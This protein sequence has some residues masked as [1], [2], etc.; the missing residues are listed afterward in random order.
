MESRDD[1]RRGGGNPA[2]ATTCIILSRS[3][4]GYLGSYHRSMF[5]AGPGPTIVAYR[6]PARGRSVLIPDRT[7]GRGYDNSISDDCAHRDSGGA[8]RGRHVC[9]HGG[10]G[11]RG[12]RLAD[13]G[14]RHRHRADRRQQRHRAGPVDLKPRAAVRHHARDRF[15]LHGD[16]Q[17]RAR[18][19]RR[20]VAPRYRGPGRDRR[21][22]Q[23]RQFLAAAAD[24]A[25]AV[26]FRHQ[27]AVSAVPRSG[28]ELHDHL[29]RKMRTRRWR[30]C[31]G[32]PT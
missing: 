21:P 13:Q 18:A 23:R 32:R 7:G 22:R 15:H 27:L 6:G 14:S 9:E 1:Q 24:S 11:A 28:R 20:D 4:A 3:G 26:P 30:A 16:Q 29:G 31:S 19:D 17:H 2:P 25:A 12:R 8:C 10:A 5:C